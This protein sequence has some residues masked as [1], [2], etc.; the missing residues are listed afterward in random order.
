M[1]AR[2]MAIVSYGGLVLILMA[3]LASAIR[4]TGSPLSSSVG[5]V[6]SWMGINLVVWAVGWA[7]HRS[8]PAS[9]LS[10]WLIALGDVLLPL[11][12]YMVSVT[13]IPPIVGNLPLSASFAALVTLAYII[14]A[15]LVERRLPL[16]GRPHRAYLFAVNLAI[17]LYFL[18]FTLGLPASL[19]SMLLVGIGGLIALL[20]HALDPPLKQHYAAAG[21]LLLLTLVVLFGPSFFPHPSSVLLTSGYLAAGWLFTLAWLNRAIGI[22]ILLGMLGWGVLAF[23]LAG[24]LSLSIGQQYHV[25]LAALGVV[26]LVGIGNGFRSRRWAAL[27]ESAYWFAFVLGGMIVIS[28]Q[29]FWDGLV[30]VHTIGVLTYRLQA[31]GS[32]QVTM[33]SGSSWSA[34]ALLLVAIS[35]AGGL[36]VRR[37]EREPA[38]PPSGGMRAVEG[39]I[40]FAAPLLLLAAS[41]AGTVLLFGEASWVIVL[42]LA[43]G[44][45]YSWASAWFGHL[46]PR[47]ALAVAGYLT[48]V[49][50]AVT[51]AYSLLAVMAAL[52]IGALILFALSEWTGAI[53]SYA[54]SVIHLAAGVVLVAFGVFPTQSTLV[55]AVFSLLLMMLTQWWIN[56]ARRI[57]DSHRVVVRIRF[58][59]SVALLVALSTLLISLIGNQYHPISFFI[60]AAMFPLMRYG[61]E[62]AW[63]PPMGRAVRSFLLLGCEMAH[64]AVGF[65]LF[66]VLQLAGARVEIYGLAFAVMSVIYLLGYAV[67]ARHRQLLSRASVMHFAHVFSLLAIGLTIWRSPLNLLAMLAWLMALTVQSRLAADPV[68]GRLHPL[69]VLRALG[70]GAI[71]IGVIN[72]LWRTIPNLAVRLPLPQAIG[73][74][75]SPRVEANYLLALGLLFTILAERE[76]TTSSKLL[77]LGLVTAGL[78]VLVIGAG[79]ISATLCLGV[80][81]LF[82]LILSRMEMRRTWEDGFRPR[83]PNMGLWLANGVLLL[84]LGVNAPW[85]QYDLSAL[86]IAIIG[87]IIVTIGWKGILP[88]YVQ[89]RFRSTFITAYILASVA[90]GVLVYTFLATYGVSIGHYGLAFATLAG[91]HVLAQWW[92]ERR[93]DDWW[94]ERVLWYGA[95][96]YVLIGSGLTFG[97]AHRHLGGA[98]AALLLALIS[99][100]MYWLRRRS[101]HQH[102]AA[103]F[104]VSAWI[105]IGRIGHVGLL[106]FYLIPVAIYL[107]WILSGAAS[108]AR[109]SL[110]PSSE[111]RMPG[112]G[113]K[114]RVLSVGLAIV[115]VLIIGYPAW[116]FIVTGRLIHLILSGA[117]AVA[118]MH[119]F[120]VTAMPPPLMYI[121]GLLLFVEAGQALRMGWTEWPLIATLVIAGMLM[122]IDMEYLSGRNSVGKN[123]S[124]SL[125]HADKESERAD[126]TSRG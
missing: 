71:V 85:G 4:L 5:F 49:L 28:Q 81:Y 65:L 75:Y 58:T 62:P 6:G 76:K 93:E 16:S 31:S 27:T 32:V 63:S 124:T 40:G 48:L 77:A 79:A 84:L 17:P 44:S 57:E 67:M 88:P 126:S 66:A 74:H 38:R 100:D 110:V 82:L 13:T 125:W 25:V 12:L 36:I 42:L 35:W 111:A 19:A 34:L 94:R 55:L 104:L 107:G 117:G 99:M 41:S 102:I 22:G 33:P 14:F 83:L 53:V 120:I 45:I 112:R 39:L 90:S 118:A 21:A 97:L 3:A 56:R 123:Q 103:I 72:V 101:L 50:A 46:Y 98:L 108:A 43:M 105:I 96:V 116:T 87:F 64:V 121:I 89:Q 91:L 54:L 113:G 47:R 29:A 60:L 23:V 24:T 15:D 68:A 92:Y 69:R 9:S 109:S 20:C 26:L 106:E 59:L 114:R 51:A 115:L 8:D 18:P 86:L 119:L 52:G 70:Y 30:Q 80:Y 11:T 95:H 37:A 61:W 2:H 73:Q 122:A 10:R 7:V 1:R 78:A